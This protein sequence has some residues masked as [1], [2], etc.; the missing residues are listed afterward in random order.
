MPMGWPFKAIY[1]LELNVF[2]S[3]MNRSQMDV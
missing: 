3:R 1:G 2:G